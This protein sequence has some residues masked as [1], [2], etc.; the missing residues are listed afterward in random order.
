MTITP[1]IIESFKSKDFD[2]EFFVS[3]AIKNSNPKLIKEQLGL[4]ESAIQKELNDASRFCT[5]VVVYAASSSDECLATLFSTR[6]NLAS[7]KRELQTLR[8]QEYDRHSR[9]VHKRDELVRAMEISKLLR[10]M[11]RLSGDISRLRAQFP[12]ETSMTLHTIEFINKACEFSSQ[13]ESVKEYSDLAD[14]DILREDVAWSQRLVDQFRIAALSQLQQV[15]TEHGSVKR[16]ILIISK[17]VQLLFTLGCLREECNSIIQSIVN[18]FAERY[19]CFVARIPTIKQAT[20]TDKSLNHFWELLDGALGEMSRV[21]GQVAMLEAVCAIMS[22]PGS[23]LPF[24]NAWEAN[25][26]SAPQELSELT[27]AFLAKA[28]TQHVSKVTEIIPRVKKSLQ[29]A[30]YLRSGIEK[31]GQE[32]RSI[33]NEMYDIV[34][35]GIMKKSI[36]TSESNKELFQTSIIV[37]RL[38]HIIR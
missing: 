10:R 20:Q 23:G 15:L 37:D 29:A 3:E 9:L 8:D 36:E 4:C 21:I 38:K 18:T 26:S 32:S 13:I 22:D 7:I 27:W 33:R 24:R 1:K 17:S 5:D 31:V 28:L 25:S 11:I 34:N 30:E 16:D 19:L 2:V 14:I 35:S 6:E 12:T